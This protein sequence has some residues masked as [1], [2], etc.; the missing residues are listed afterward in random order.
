MKREKMTNKTIHLDQKKDYCNIRK[1]KV[2][3]LMLLYCF[4]KEQYVG[5]KRSYNY[6]FL[7]RESIFS[8]YLTFAFN[9]KD[10]ENKKKT[11]KKQSTSTY[12][13]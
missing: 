8:I 1:N 3:F 4:Y 10:R 6:P 5:I 11:K 12:K 13:V 2:V 9:N 7:L